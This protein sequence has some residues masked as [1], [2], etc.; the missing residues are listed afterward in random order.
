M[1][2]HFFADVR[3][4]FGVFSSILAVPIIATA[5]LAVDFSLALVE[6]TTVQGL[7]DSAVL[8]AAASNSTSAAE[9][10]KTVEDHFNG[11]S[12]G[13]VTETVSIKSVEYRA[14]RTIAIE[15]AAEIPLTLGKVL[16]DKGFPV[17]VSA[18][19]QQ[20][21]STPVDVALVLDNT[22]SMSGEK[23]KDLKKASLSLVSVLEKANE[24]QVRLGLVPFSNYVNVGLDR[25]RESW[26]SVPND[27]SKTEKVC[28]KSRPLLSKS[29]CEQVSKTCSNDGVAY[30][31]LAEQCSS[32]TYGPEQTTCRDKV[33]TFRWNGCVGS[34]KAP[35]D[36][37]DELQGQ[38]YEGL[39]NENCGSA[40]LA[41]SSNMATVRKAIDG[42]KAQN[43]TYI[44][45]GILWGWTVLSGREPFTEAATSS[46]V[47]DRY[48]IIMTDG[49]NTLRA[50]APKHVGDNSGAV[51][52]RLTA[53]TCENAKLDGIKIFTVGVGDLGK[54]T[55]EVLAACASDA[56]YALFAD[57]TSSLDN[58]FKSF[59]VAMMSP[60]LVE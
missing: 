45:A 38:K 48:M 54:E 12:K 35:L 21:F 1:F 39:L 10:K 44:P 9:I 52:L 34:R 23:L 3:G 59:A 40:I 19:A 18:I 6:K 25:R 4:N 28:T 53:K 11:G 29:G 60:R 27:Y 41:L 50:A 14:D 26:I 20:G 58:I 31:Y 22:G 2:K 49:A 55:Q 37:T 13:S 43:N 17:T 32:Y 47:A 15:V 46:M 42:M 30:T 16:F 56:K 5:G 57:D 36:E 51:A 8:A 7:A 33:T 24:G